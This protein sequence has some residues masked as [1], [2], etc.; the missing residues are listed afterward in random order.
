MGT[1]MFPGSGVPAAD[2]ANSLP[3]VDTKEGCPELWYSTSRCQPRFDPAA[4][5]AMLAEIMNLIN[6][7]EVSYDCTQLNNVEKAVRYI[8]QRGLPRGVTLANGPTAYTGVLDPPVTR[9]NDYMPL[10]IVPNGNN[11]GPVTL[12][13]GMGIKP[14]LR[15]DGLPLVASDLVAN[16]PAE[17]AYFGGFWY[18][19][20]LVRS[21]ISAVT[22]SL[23]LNTVVYNSGSGN[24]LVPAGIYLLRE[25]EVTGGGGGG[26]GG[27]PA[28]GGG[29]GGTTIRGPLV[30]SPGQS[31]PWTVGVG[32][33][34]G[35]LASN[36]G[37]GANSLFGTWVAAGG[38]G[39]A[40]SGNPG[41]APGPSTGGSEIYIGGQGDAAWQISGGYQRGGYG[42][43]TI[44]GGTGGNGSIN[45]GTNG[46][47]GNAAGGGGGGGSSGGGGFTNGGPGSAGR[48]LIRY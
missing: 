14:L 44:S 47:P 33:T 21:Q 23:G 48:I 18:V 9:Y 2:A 27:G 11:T 31:I 28:G 38:G 32:G 20:S 46:N 26:G 3:D 24:F 34:P 35:T 29:N 12:D 8:V 6:K 15:S 1:M 16:V 4:A 13:F 39:G 25:V 7:G 5:N 30:V 45:G 41:P 42:G 22:Q 40:T 17:I 43:W 10:T 37:F 36:A 19:L